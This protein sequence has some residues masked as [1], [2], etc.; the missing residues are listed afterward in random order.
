MRAGRKGIFGAGMCAVGGGLAQAVRRRIQAA[1]PSPADT[2]R[3]AAGNRTAHPPDDTTARRRIQTARRYE[4]VRA[5][6][7]PRNDRTAFEPAQTRAVRRGSRNLPG[8]TSCA[9]PETRTSQPSRRHKP[10]TVGYEPRNPPATQTARRR[11]QTAPDSSERQAVG[12]RIQAAPHS[13]R[14]EPGRPKETLWRHTQPDTGRTI[15]AA[16]PGR[17]EVIWLFGNEEGGATGEQ[18]RRLRLSGNEGKRSNRR[19][20]PAG[21]PP[22]SRPPSKTAKNPPSRQTHRSPASPY[23]LLQDRRRPKNAKKNRKAPPPAG[24]SP[25]ATTRQQT[26]AG[27]AGPQRPALCK[28]AGTPPMITAAHSGGRRRCLCFQLP[29]YPKFRSIR[30]GVRLFEKISRSARPAS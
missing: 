11:K 4:L 30:Q 10:R 26:R 22:H 18:E 25:A 16:R 15:P 29:Y 27:P 28:E 5:G 8:D 19:P 17:K 3:R 2:N 12:Y 6:A 23:T 21:A 7:L 9:P 20:G 24:P 14:Y 1:Q 13:Q